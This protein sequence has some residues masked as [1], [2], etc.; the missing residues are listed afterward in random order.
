MQC[1]GCGF[2]NE[3]DNK[4][5][6]MCGMS[7]PA[8]GESMDSPAEREPL[9][10]DL[11]L[12]ID[13]TESSDTS[14]QG[15]GLALDLGEPSAEDTNLD[16]ASSPKDAAESSNEL[17]LDLPES[18]KGDELSF[19]MDMD[20]SES[21]IN[22]DESFDADKTQE[23]DLSQQLSENEGALDLDLNQEPPV[24][25]TESEQNLDLSGEVEQADMG[26]ELDLGAIP[27]DTEDPFAAPQNE[28]ENLPEDAIAPEKLE[29]QPEQTPMTEEI[30][31]DLDAGQP[32]EKQAGTPE[33]QTPPPPWLTEFL[34]KSER[35]IKT[36][37]GINWRIISL[38]SCSSCSEH[39][40]NRIFC[41]FQ[42]VPPEN[43]IAGNN[44][45]TSSQSCSGIKSDLLIWINK[46]VHNEALPSSIKGTPF[47]VSLSICF[48]E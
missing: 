39:V 13:D 9:D 23:L 34:I 22:L 30:D 41:V 37:P 8:E 5:C 33:Q 18:G 4:F 46:E 25:V 40:L 35:S 6:N 26:N 3:K 15:D 45:P 32:V 17:N 12:E 2:E 28:T 7:L 27:E 21:E 1:P 10:L 31:I 20:S 47:R 11:S 24:D 16:L 44:L 38:F 43:L 36:K 42:I 19:D 48:F 14:D 29:Q